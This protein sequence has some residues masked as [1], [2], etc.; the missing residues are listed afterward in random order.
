MDIFW[1]YYKCYLLKILEVVG[2]YLKQIKD[3]YWELFI[4]FEIDDWRYK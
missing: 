1:K 4:L 3:V 2:Y